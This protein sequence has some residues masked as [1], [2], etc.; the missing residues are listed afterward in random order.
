M[1]ILYKLQCG[2]VI[3]AKGKAPKVTLPCPYCMTYVKVSDVIV[4]EWHSYCL[5]CKYSHWH[6]DSEELSK[7]AVNRHRAGKGNQQHRTFH[8]KR[9]RPD[10]VNMK[11][12]MI[13]LG[14]L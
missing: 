10:S 5:S 2:D 13:R 4:N 8:D 6:G 9:R 11:R 7:D 1:D 3:G 14:I 12:K